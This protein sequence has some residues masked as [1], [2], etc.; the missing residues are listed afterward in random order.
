MGGIQAVQ[1]GRNYMCLSHSRRVHYH[2]RGM[3]L[4]R[5]QMSGR[6]HNKIPFLLLVFPP[7]PIV[8]KW[9][10]LVALIKM[11]FCEHIFATTK[12]RTTKLYISTL[13][14]MMMNNTIDFLFSATRVLFPRYVYCTVGG[15]GRGAG[16]LYMSVQAVFGCI[17]RG[18]SGR[19]CGPLIAYT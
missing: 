1:I 5:A 8:Q 18:A 13:G 3:Q 12:T 10:L 9:D 11:Y 16:H 19:R 14:E 15:G 6:R 2:H 4:S 17:W 7:A